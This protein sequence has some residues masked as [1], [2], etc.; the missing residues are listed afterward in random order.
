MI[1]SDKATKLKRVDENSFVKMIFEYF[2]L[3]FKKKL[4]FSTTIRE[5]QGNCAFIGS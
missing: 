4:C 3:I 1:N 2:L 5:K